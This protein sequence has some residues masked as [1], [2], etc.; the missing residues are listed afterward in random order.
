MNTL[1]NAP[2]PTRT[3][4]FMPLSMGRWLLR[5]V[6]QLLGTHEALALPALKRVI[7]VETLSQSAKALFPPHKCG[8]SH[9]SQQELESV[10]R[11]IL[12]KSHSAPT[13]GCVAFSCHA[14]DGGVKHSR[15]GISCA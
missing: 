2:K 8:G 12:R 15:T 5:S 11:V 4:S 7:R 3:R 9:R 6:S 13:A 10:T 14:P 1:R